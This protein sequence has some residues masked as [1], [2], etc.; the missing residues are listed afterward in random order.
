MDWYLL[1]L[2]QLF[3]YIYLLVPITKHPHD[4]ALGS[5]VG[6]YAFNWI[7]VTSTV[8]LIMFSEGLKSFSPLN[9][10]QLGAWLE[11]LWVA[12]NWLSW[13]KL[14]AQLNGSWLRAVLF[15]TLGVLQDWSYIRV[16]HTPLI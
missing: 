1:F 9:F 13:P 2:M 4:V 3:G 10:R 11:W 7:P 6:K 14:V 12:L 15:A 8:S 5:T 16:F